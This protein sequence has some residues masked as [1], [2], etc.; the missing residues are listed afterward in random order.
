[1]NI[2]T[3]PINIAPAADLLKAMG[4]E[5]RLL[6]LCELGGGEYSVGE[7]QGR[8]GLA[9]SAL[10]QHLAVL[11]RHGLVETRR[12]SRTVFYSIA[13]PAVR[14]VVVTLSRL[15]CPIRVLT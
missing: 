13:N 2:Q 4:N 8:V 7:L 9:Q 14:G 15:F 1:M 10:S 5:H 11:R 6:I 3:A 12:N